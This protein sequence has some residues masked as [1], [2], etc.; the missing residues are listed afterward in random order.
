MTGKS[1]VYSSLKIHNCQN[2]DQN[3]LSCE[4][5]NGTHFGLC[6]FSGLRLDPREPP[7]LLLGA[8]WVAAWWLRGPTLH[9]SPALQATQKAERWACRFS[10][11]IVLDDHGPKP[12][13]LKGLFSLSVPG[14]P[15]FKDL[16]VWGPQGT[17]GFERHAIESPVTG[18][19]QHCELFFWG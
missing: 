10:S 6:P 8:T 7:C 5:R 19:G 9:S 13:F 11:C 15:W 12:S 2:T 18:S 17:W 14:W 16:S 1:T 4:K 3:L